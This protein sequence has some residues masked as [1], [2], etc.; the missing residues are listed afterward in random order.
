M[1]LLILRHGIAE[2]RG[3][4]DN[5]DERMLT[6]E[7]RKKTRRIARR[8]AELDVKLQI[9]LTSPLVRAHQTAEILIDEGVAPRLERFAPLAPGG[10]LSDLRVWLEANPELQAVGLVGHQPDLGSWA[11]TLLWGSFRQG[12]DIKKAGVVRIDL[13]HPQDQGRLVWFLPPRVLL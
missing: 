11:E 8:L 12:F 7:G 10:A 3:T 9:V 2:E 4:R 1:D 5:D 6:D 13:L